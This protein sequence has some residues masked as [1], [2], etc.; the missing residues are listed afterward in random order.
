VNRAKM[1][2]GTKWGTNMEILNVLAATVAAYAFGAVWYISLSKQWVAAAGIPMDAQ[3][4]PQGNGQ[5]AP[6]VIGFVCILLVAGMMR[7][8]FQMMAMDTIG[9]GI[10]G[11]FGIGAFF[12]T[13]WVL[14]NNTYGMRPLRLTLIDGTYSIVGCTIIGVV[15][16]LF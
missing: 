5:P 10:M 11:G 4:R 7:H 8:V 6:M 9:E 13:P 3:G 14:M 15:L 16:T 1:R 2:A 12:I